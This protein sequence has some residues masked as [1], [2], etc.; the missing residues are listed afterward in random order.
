MKKCI[1]R[2]F[3]K[4]LQLKRINK[5]IKKINKFLKKNQ[6]Q[7]FSFIVNIPIKIKISKIINLIKIFSKMLICFLYLKLILYFFYQIIVIIITIKTYLLI[8]FFIKF[9]VFLHSAPTVL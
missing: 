3:F 9:F 5:K 8:Y 4:L 7:H 6:L 2:N 1:N